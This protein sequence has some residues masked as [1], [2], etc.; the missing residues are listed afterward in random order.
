[1]FRARGFSS[2][3][4]G[5]RHNGAMSR[6]ILID[7]RVNKYQLFVGFCYPFGFLR[8]FFFLR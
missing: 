6:M 8:C 5:E 3:G 4:D 7:Y 1:M 2:D